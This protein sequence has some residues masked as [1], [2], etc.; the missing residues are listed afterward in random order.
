MPRTMLRYSLEKLDKE[1]KDYF[2]GRR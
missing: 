2:M 1:K